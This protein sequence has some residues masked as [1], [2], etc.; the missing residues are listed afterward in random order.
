MASTASP[1]RLAYLCLAYGCVGLGAAGIALP[2]LP[3]TPFLLV[4]AWA[5]PKG[6]ARLDAW[7]HNHPHFGPPLHAWHEQRAVP[8]R[9]KWL[10]CLLLLSSWLILWLTTDSPLVP[11][12]TGI[13]FLSVAAFLLT[14]P[15]AAPEAA[16]EDRTP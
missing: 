13:L 5:A 12:I 14:R 6:S 3:T 2:L 15:D 1:R 10:A 7:L 16:R 8:R 9:A 11:V 4:A